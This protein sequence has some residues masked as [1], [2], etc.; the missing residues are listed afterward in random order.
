MK[1]P[2]VPVQY[3]NHTSETH[4]GRYIDFYLLLTQQGVFWTQSRQ[5]MGKKIKLDGYTL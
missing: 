1:F 2:L 4:S 5:E 3:E